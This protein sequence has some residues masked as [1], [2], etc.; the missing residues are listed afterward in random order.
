MGRRGPWQEV[1]WLQGVRVMEAKP[2]SENLPVEM[3][4]RPM[5]GLQEPSAG[6][7]F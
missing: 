4:L 7:A 1:W 2:H 6:L 5:A 3:A